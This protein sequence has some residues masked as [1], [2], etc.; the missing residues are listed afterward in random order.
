MLGLLHNFVEFYC[1]IDSY[2]EVDMGLHDHILL[3]FDTLAV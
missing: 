2:I 1:D 3:V